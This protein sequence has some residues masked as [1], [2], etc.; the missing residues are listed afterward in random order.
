MGKEKKRDRLRDIVCTQTLAV[1]LSTC[2]STEAVSFFTRA[3]IRTYG[4]WSRVRAQSPLSNGKVWN[5]ELVHRGRK[6]GS[7]GRGPSG[8]NA[9]PL[10]TRGRLI[11]LQSAN[12]ISDRAYGHER[13]KRKKQGE[14]ERE[15]TGNE[16]I[17]ARGAFRRICERNC[18]A[19]QGGCGCNAPRCGPGSAPC[20]SWE[21]RQFLMPRI[22]KGPDSG[23]TPSPRS[24][25]RSLLFQWDAHSDPL[26][27]I[28]LSLLPSCSLS[29]VRIAFFFHS[30]PDKTM[31]IGRRRSTFD[32]VG[33]SF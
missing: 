27:Y 23:T 17:N 29:P 5:Y 11:D 32:T 16:R 13:N 22:S 7:L 19:L 6:G 15:R 3:F 2:S 33:L 21:N 1:T 9:V 8:D 20:A 26:W 10:A 25:G 30:R 18:I 14:R 28:Y 12:Y 31:V 24:A 4:L